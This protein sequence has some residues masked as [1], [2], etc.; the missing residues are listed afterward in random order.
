[1]KTFFK[2]IIPNFNSEKFIE[3]CINS[4]LNQTFKDYKVIIIDDCSTDNSL[5]IIKKYQDKRIR[6]I[7]LDKKRWNGGTRNIG[8]D[9]PIESEY[10][11]FIDNDDWFTSDDVFQLI[12]DTI[13][14]NNYPDCISLSYQCLIGNHLS[15]QVLIRNTPEEMVNS[16]YVAAWTKCIKSELV[17]KF[18]ENTLMEDVSQ[19]I[20]QCDLINTIVSIDTPIVVWNRNNND[21]CSINPNEKRKSSEFRQIADIMDLELEH[22]YCKNHKDWRIQCMKETIFSG[23]HL[24]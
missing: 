14:K 10:T 9:Y 24:Y 3:K 11:L 5:N 20:K 8:I 2:V 18:P 22:D 13:T 19:H 23:G 12:Y 21:S 7:E 6:L 16:L 17:Q 4:I 15:N 1:M